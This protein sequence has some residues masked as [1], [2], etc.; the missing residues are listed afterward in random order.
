MIHITPAV[1]DMPNNVGGRLKKFSVVVTHPATTGGW[2]YHTDYTI[3]HRFGAAVTHVTVRTVLGA[4][5][6][7]RKY[8]FMYGNPDHLGYFEVYN[9]PGIDLNLCKVRMYRM[10]S[11][12]KDYLLTAYRIDATEDWK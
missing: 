4:G 8:D 10:S 9:R 6:W 7:D 3:N 2:G 1:A 11:T 5:S 12:T